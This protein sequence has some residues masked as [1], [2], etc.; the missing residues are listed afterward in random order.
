VRALVR[1]FGIEDLRRLVLVHDELDLPP[2]RVRLKLGGGTAGHNGLESV[3][4]HLHDRDFARVRVGIGKPPGTMT[5]AR[6]V[7]RRPSRSERALLDGAV[8]EAVAAVKA[9]VAD[10]V[11]TA[12]NRY[13]TRREGD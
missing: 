8:R 13:N 3:Q 6:F 10:G 5:G 11:E 2:G 12:M 4:A 9:I 1:R 7:L